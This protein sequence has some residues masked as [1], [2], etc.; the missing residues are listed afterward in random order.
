[1]PVRK[2]SANNDK[3]VFRR[4]FLERSV[5]VSRIESRE[6]DFSNRIRFNTSKFDLARF[7][8][9]RIRIVSY[10]T[11]R[12]FRRRIF[13][14]R[15]DTARN[16]LLKSLRT[17][18]VTETVFVGSA[19]SHFVRASTLI[20]RQPDYSEQIGFFYSVDFSKSFI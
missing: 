4:T 12:K 16:V 1:M 3:H 10:L 15:C 14:G 17:D 19:M 6:I 18:R 9:A 20:I 8:L 7:R 13:V 2:F 11:S 5:P